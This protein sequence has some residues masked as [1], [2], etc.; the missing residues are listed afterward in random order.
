MSLLNKLIFHQPICIFKYDKTKLYRQSNNI[1]VK[2][3]TDY[4]NS[5][6]KT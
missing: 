5:K 2:I 3:Q 1:R 6:E 4:Q